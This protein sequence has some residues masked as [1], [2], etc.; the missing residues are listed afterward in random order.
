MKTKAMKRMK[1][2]KLSSWI[3]VPVCAKLV[4]QETMLL[5]LFS[6]RL[7]VDLATRV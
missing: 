7:S 3:T 2:F 4:S 1:M 5:V 6:R